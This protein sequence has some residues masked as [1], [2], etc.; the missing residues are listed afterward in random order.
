MK[1][2]YFYVL[3]YLTII[4]HSCNTADEEISLQEYEIGDIGPAGGRIFYDAGNHD[5][6]WRYIEAAPTDLF[7]LEWGCFDTPVLE[8]RNNAVG[9]GLTNSMAIVTFHDQFD[10]YYNNPA[11]CSEKSN[12]TVA[13]KAC[14]EVEINGYD[15]WHLPSQQEML[16]MYERLHLSGLGRFDDSI[17]YWSSTEHENNTAVSTDFSNGRQGFLCKQCYQVTKIRAAR[18]F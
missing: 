17:L 8:A 4:F 3:L 2:K 15:D 18:Y 9:T 5:N 1:A 7:G 16:L 10:D 6:G 13:A 14:L 11:E 12:G